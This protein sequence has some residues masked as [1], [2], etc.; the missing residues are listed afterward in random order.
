MDKLALLQTYVVLLS[1]YVYSFL[2]RGRRLGLPGES[3][4]SLGFG[5]RTFGFKV[6]G[7]PGL[8]GFQGLSYLE[9]PSPAGSQGSQ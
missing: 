9:I 1:R 3:Y 4:G 7:V 8:K 5:S 6:W 2:A